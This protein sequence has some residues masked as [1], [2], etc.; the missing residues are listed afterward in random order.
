MKHSR[1][2]CRNLTNEHCEIDFFPFFSVDISFNIDDLSHIVADVS[3][4]K[5]ER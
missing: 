1:V 5:R 4:V 2:C 3:L